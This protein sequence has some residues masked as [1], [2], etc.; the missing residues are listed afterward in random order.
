MDFQQQSCQNSPSR[1]SIEGKSLQLDTLV[2]SVTHV[3]HRLDQKVA[4][5]MTVPSTEDT[6]QESVGRVEDTRIHPEMVRRKA[7]ISVAM[8][9]IFP[10]CFEVRDREQNGDLS[11][12]RDLKEVGGSVWD[13]CVT[14]TF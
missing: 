6:F 13:R 8:L 2:E 3:F 5:V 12:R 11:L 1:A 14:S 9:P 7:T 10:R 4:V